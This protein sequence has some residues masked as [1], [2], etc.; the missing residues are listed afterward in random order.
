[1]RIYIAGGISGNLSPM[2][3]RV[4]L[5]I[6]GGGIPNIKKEIEKFINEGISC[7]DRAMDIPRSNIRGGVSLM[8]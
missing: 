2:W 1:M 8:K 6:I 5:T 4:Y 7:R 3:R